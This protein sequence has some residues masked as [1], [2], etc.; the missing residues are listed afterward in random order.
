MVWLSRRDLEGDV[1][2]KVAI[3]KLGADMHVDGPLRMGKTAKI[4]APHVNVYKG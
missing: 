1:T 4:F 2:G 3:G